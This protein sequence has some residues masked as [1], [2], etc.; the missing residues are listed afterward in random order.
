MCNTRKPKPKHQATKRASEHQWLRRQNASLGRD[1][2]N[3]VE[4][5]KTNKKPNPSVRGRRRAGVHPTGRENMARPVSAIRTV[6]AVEPKAHINANKKK[7]NVTQ[8]S[9]EDIP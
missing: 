5:Y 6:N 1:C 3:A 9:E 2:N 8:D 4:L 7:R